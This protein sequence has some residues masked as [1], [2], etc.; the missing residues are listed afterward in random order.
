[1]WAR[2]PKRK[3]FDHVETMNGSP[4]ENFDDGARR[5]QPDDLVK[6]FDEYGV[7]DQS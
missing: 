4:C 5:A 2:D 1:M 3:K 7:G 6:E